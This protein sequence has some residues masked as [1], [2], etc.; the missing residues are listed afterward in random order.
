M[1]ELADSIRANGIIQPL[2]VRRSQD[3]KLQLIA[4]ERR[5]RAAK[6]AGLKQVPVVIRMSTDKESLEMALIE[7]VQRE[8]LN[9]VDI[10]LSYY[11][12][13]EDFR[14]TQEELAKR[15]GK[16]R[17]NVANHLRLL[18]LPDEIIQDLRDAR[19]SFGH[20]RAILALE[21]SLQRIQVKNQIIEKKL[22]VRETERLIGE[23]LS[24]EK[25]EQRAKRQ[26]PPNSMQELSDRLARA[27]GTK[28][29]IAGDEHRGKIQ[30][31]FFSREDLDRIVEQMLR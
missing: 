9:C 2:I 29:K 31:E 27:Y 8:D 26:S 30:I 19:L 3:G 6:M 28:V 11:Q 13:I 18:R 12:L 20:G 24:A 21:D 16:E 23:L 15:V 1:Q 5:L 4:G 25:K 10:A 7:N 22:S 14:L 17:S